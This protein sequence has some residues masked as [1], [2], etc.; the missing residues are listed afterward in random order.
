MS[1]Q[2]IRDTKTLTRPSTDV[3]FVDTSLL[4][5]FVEEFHALP[6]NFSITYSDDMLTRTKVDWYPASFLPT[7]QAITAKYM[8]LITQDIKRREELGFTETWN[9]ETY[10]K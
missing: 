7:M 2:W 6:I 10:D 8:D 3:R 5:D 9:R 1:E 4:G